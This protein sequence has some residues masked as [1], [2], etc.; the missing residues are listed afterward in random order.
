MKG[1]VLPDAD[2]ANRGCV[3][4]PALCHQGHLR[5]VG[6]NPKRVKSTLQHGLITLREEVTPSLRAKVGSWRPVACSGELDEP[7][8]QIAAS[9]LAFT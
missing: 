3:N 9:S 7:V 1:G 8:V 5:L 4:L 2:T 6:V